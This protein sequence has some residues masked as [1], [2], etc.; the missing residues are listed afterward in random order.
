MSLGSCGQ[1]CRTVALT[2]A[3]A[4][5]ERFARLHAD[6]ER[7]KAALLSGELYRQEVQPSPAV[8]A[9]TD[10]VAATTARILHLDPTPVIKFYRR[11]GLL[12]ARGYTP[13]PAIAPC[14]T[15]WIAD[16][17]TEGELIEALFHEH[18]HARVP[19][20]PESDAVLCG[21]ALLKFWRWQPGFRVGCRADFRPAITPEIPY[22]SGGAKV[23]R[24]RLEPGRLLI[25]PTTGGVFLYY[26]L[27]HWR[28][29]WQLPRVTR[30]CNCAR[31]A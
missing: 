7:R 10:A 3:K 12:S 2:D 14:R 27:D 23:A 26:G 28:K 9:L 24:E 5:R 16:G 21:R 19:D 4:L 8:R 11:D 20:A 15:I 30:G 22:L 25:E 1:N 6:F 18:F 31:A 17:L 29:V 13:V